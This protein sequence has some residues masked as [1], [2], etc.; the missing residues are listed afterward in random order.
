MNITAYYFLTALIE[1]LVVFVFGIGSPAAAIFWPYLWLHVVHYL[2]FDYQI[3]VQY[4]LAQSMLVEITPFVTT[5][6]IFSGY[7]LILFHLNRRA[8]ARGFPDHEQWKLAFLLHAKNMDELNQIQGGNFRSRTEWIMAKKIGAT[9]LED[10]EFRVN[11]EKLLKIISTFKGGVP[12]Q[13]NH[14]AQLAGFTEKQTTK[15]LKQILPD[16]PVGQYLE[17]EQVFIYT[18]KTAE[19]R[20]QDVKAIIKVFFSYA[21]S[22]EQ[23]YSVK[24]TARLLNKKQGIKEVYFWQEHASGSII[25]YMETRVKESDTCVFFYSPEAASSEPVQM[26]RDMAVYQN[27]HII[28]VFTDID[29]IPYILKYR[30]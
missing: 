22:D 30:A 28:P 12:V 7:W 17:N 8:R 18:G 23:K 26:E 3:Y 29:D 1:G 16:E 27:K 24:E 19:Q 20:E 5:I 10:Y 2:L 15:L 13:V 9:R 11:K 6:M 14:V 21:T 25:D 4:F